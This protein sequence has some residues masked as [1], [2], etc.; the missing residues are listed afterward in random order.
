MRALVLWGALALAACTSGSSDG[1]AEVKWDR[2]VC[3]SCGMVMSDRH[4]AAEVRAPSGAVSKFDDIGCALKW[5]DEQP[6]ANDPATKLWVARGSDG[7]WLDGRTAHYVA[8][9]TSP[10]GFNFSAVD[11]DQPGNDLAAQREVVR[12]MPRAR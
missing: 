6:F 9:K 12:S 8:G 4:F 1:P 7:A 11:G 2:D 3:R 10:M 5:L